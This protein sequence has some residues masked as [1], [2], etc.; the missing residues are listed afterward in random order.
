MLL[1]LLATQPSHQGS[2]RW[3]ITVEGID[4]A[5]DKIYAIKH[6]SDTS[7]IYA[8]SD[9]FRA[10]SISRR[11][12]RCN[13]N[14]Q[15]VIIL[16]LPILPRK[17]NH[18]IIQNVTNRGTGHRE[19]YRHDNALDLYRLR[20]ISTVYTE[21]SEAAP[22]LTACCKSRRYIAIDAIRAMIKISWM[23]VAWP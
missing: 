22:V 6:C 8:A 11:D 9:S 14:L 3:V 17:L 16:S 21:E 20:L 13:T 15:V 2:K 7:A 19:C 5:R 10:A 4:D 1:N 23:Q 18:S 12:I